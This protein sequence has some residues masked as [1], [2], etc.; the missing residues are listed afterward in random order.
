LRVN[1]I[2]G[3]YGDRNSSQTSF[4]T[5]WHDWQVT[6][7]KKPLFILALFPCQKYDLTERIRI[8]GN[9]KIAIHDHTCMMIQFWP[10]KIWEKG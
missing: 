3:T 8:F 1:H 7:E 9:Q 4:S 2:G 10:T 5:D 6:G